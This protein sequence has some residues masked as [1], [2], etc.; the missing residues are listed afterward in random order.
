[1]QFSDSPIAGSINDLVRLHFDVQDQKCSDNGVA[2]CTIYGLLPFVHV[3]NF[4]DVMSIETALHEGPWPIH[5]SRSPGG[6]KEQILTIL[7]AQAM[8]LSQLFRIEMAAAL[9]VETLREIDSRNNTPE[10][11]RC[12][13]SHDY[14]DANMIMD[15]AMQ[16][17]GER[18]Q[19]NHDN[20]EL[21]ALWNR[22]WSVTREQGFAQ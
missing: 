1:M 20:Y 15:A 2:S 17:R 16:K 8:E 5:Y 7:D 11:D 13:A 10:Y 4:G 18:F 6:L 3:L 9:P 12:C 14:L 19:T 22:A 21:T